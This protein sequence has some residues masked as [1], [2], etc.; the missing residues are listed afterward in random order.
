[1]KA[2]HIHDY[3]GLDVLHYEDASRPTPGAGEVLIR[4]HAT[5]I[6]PF[7]CAVR[8]GYMGQYFNYTFPLILGTDVSGVV[9]EVG[10][11]VTN[12][13]PG[14]IVYTRA[15][16]YKDGAHA[17]YVLA[18]AADIVAK[19]QSLDHIHAAALPH[20]TLTAW[21][22]LIEFADLSAGQTVLIHAA[23]GGVGHIAVQLAKW[24]GAKVIG[25]ASV[26][27]PFLDELGVDQAIDYS[28]TAFEDVV[29]DVDVVLDLLGG[30]TQQRSWKVLKPGGILLSTV[31][32]PSQ[33]I[34]MAH[35]VRQRMIGTSPPIRKVLTEAAKMVDD[36]HLKPFVS[37]VLPL[38]EIQKAHEMIEGRHTRGKIVLQVVN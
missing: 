24:R 38:Q 34:A 26:N 27:L 23:A 37:A 30:E 14:E 22:G 29:Q 3:G 32:P 5:T 7:D 17:E 8:A 16:V 6:N 10:E 33:E 12:V 20:V 11:G 1:M 25:T 28:A 9:E 4:V 18:F 19:P 2:V 21:Q 36:G 13:S 15:G 35:G 31:Q